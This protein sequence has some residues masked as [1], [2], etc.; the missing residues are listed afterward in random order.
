MD[1][2]GKIVI[3]RYIVCAAAAVLFASGLGNAGF[4]AEA[5]PNRVEVYYFHGNFRCVNCHNMEKWTRQ[6]VE[7]DFKKEIDS[8]KLTFKMI[9]T[10]I[11]GSEHY[12]AD[13]QL[14]TKSV[15]LAL[16]KDGKEVRYENLT[17][18]WDYLRSEEGFR[19]YVKG[20]I[21]K[22]LKEI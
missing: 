15:V 22:Y 13:Y 16:V 5:L 1:N 2:G 8:G 6:T 20:E 14:Y 4:A 7:S 18:V 21:E 19:R 17:K 12:M 9:N 10:D 11:K 3:K